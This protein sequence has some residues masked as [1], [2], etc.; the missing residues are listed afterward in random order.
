MTA[1][2]V[3]LSRSASRENAGV[4]VVHGTKKFRDRVHGPFAGPGEV[5][6]TVLGNWYA[7]ILCWKPLVAMFVNETTRLPVFMPLAP[8]ARLVD[9]FPTMVAVLLQAHGV[10][11]DSSN[12]SW[13]A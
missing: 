9:R 6:T 3:L 10:N 11:G 7:T 5:S 4:L 1:G 13:S 12:P 8:A 2:E